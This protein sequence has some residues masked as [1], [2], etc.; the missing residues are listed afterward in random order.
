MTTGIAVTLLAIALAANA[1]AAPGERGADLVSR[2]MAVTP[3]PEH[4]RILYLKH[5]SKCHTPHAW[6]D[7]PRAIPALAGQRE[8]YLIEQLAHFASG[9]RKGS[10]THGPVPALAGQR[11]SYLI[12]QLAHFASGERKGSVT[13]G[14]VMHEILQPP[15]LNRPQAIGDLAAYLSR[16][17]RNPQPEHAATRAPAI[18]KGTYT[19]ACAA[20]HGTDGAGSDKGTIPAIG[21]QHYGYLLAQLS[22]F[23][24]GL[25]GHPLGPDVVS[26]LSDEE[27]QAVADYVSRLAYLSSVSAP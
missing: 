12:E 11:E 19:K 3:D 27:Q 18:G 5:C 22:G 20:C 4:G 17:G 7:G 9:E 21:G 6:G 8:S 15:D 13:H 23:A 14:P 25:R 16:A 1:T 2:A 26:G 24:S 10:V